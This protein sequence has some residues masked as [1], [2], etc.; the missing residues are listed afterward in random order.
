MW[1]VMKRLIKFTSRKKRR[2]SNNSLATGTTRKIFQSAAFT[3][4]Y[5]VGR[6]FE[7]I[8]KI[9]ECSICLETVDNPHVVDPCDHV[10]CGDC[11][12][13]WEAT[14]RNQAECP[15]CRVQINITENPEFCVNWLLK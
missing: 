5:E 9:V 15:T 1:K 11:I 3:N 8:T 10:F 13:L 6:T 2:T 14:R 7:N 4:H 12:A